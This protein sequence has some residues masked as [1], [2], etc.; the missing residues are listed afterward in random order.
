MTKLT[1]RQIKQ[2]KLFLLLVPFLAYVAVF[3]YVPLFGWS[4]AFLKFNPGLRIRDMKW[5]GLDNFRALFKYS[6]ALKTVMTNTMS[7]SFLSLSTSVLPVILAILISM[8][9]GKKLGR[10]VQSIT[11][12]PNFISWVLVYSIFFCLFAPETGVV[13]QVLMGVGF[14]S[15]PLNLLG[16]VEQ[17]WFIQIGIGVWKGLGWGA[18][19][20]LAAIAGIDQ[21]LY[22]SAAIDGANRFQSTIH[23]TLPGLANTYMVLFLLAI[24]S[25][26]S[27]GFEQYWVFQNALTRDKLEVFDTYVY[28]LAMVNQQYSF[29]TAM[30][31]MR[32]IVSIIL[33]FCANQVSKRIRGESIV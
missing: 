6:G 2:I 11:T 9:P 21:E 30:G 4:Y 22:E 1:G 26:L 27:N 5:V 8:L 31:M 7:I 24:A 10:I 14:L 20:Y 25:I 33:L 15:N 13:N 32:S 23:I 17:A 3:S 18:I 16:N 19:V 12:I 29:S 28:R